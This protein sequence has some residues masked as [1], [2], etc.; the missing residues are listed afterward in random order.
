LGVWIIGDNSQLPTPLYFLIGAA[1]TG[2]FS[3]STPSTLLES[4]VGALL[5]GFRSGFGSKTIG[6]TQSTS[7]HLQCWGTSLG[8]GDKLSKSWRTVSKKAPVSTSINTVFNSLKCCLIMYFPTFSSPLIGTSRLDPL[9][10][11]TSKVN[12]D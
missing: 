11:T 5:I 3:G 1:G 2:L 12:Y 4:R 10:S 7:H 6:Q 9:Y 8:S